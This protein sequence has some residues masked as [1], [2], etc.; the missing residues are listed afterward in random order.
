MNDSGLLVDLKGVHKSYSTPAGDVQALRQIDLQIRAGEFVAVTGKSGA[1]KSTL[2]N[3]VTGI[4]RP[5]AGEVWMGSRPVH[6]MTEDQIAH[7]RGQTVGV[8]F[9]FFHLL[10]MLT[11]AQN[12]MLPMDFAGLYRAPGERR[13]RAL[14]LLERVGIAGHADK[15]P[16]AVSGGQRQRVAIAR[17]LANNPVFLAADE[18]T[19]NLDSATARAVLD[20]FEELAAEG[21]AILLVTHDRSMA[22]RADRIVRIADGAI[23][24]GVDR[25]VSDD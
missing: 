17:A 15:L 13:A 18:P 1:G 12:V 19:G 5:T 10:P 2:V 23:V 22:A 24:A 9:Q 20:L 8:V 11:C 21:T 16:G 6:D 25:Q 14:H 3:M 7:W 4:D